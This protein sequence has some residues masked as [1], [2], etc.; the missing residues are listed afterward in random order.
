MRGIEKGRKLGMV[1]KM[2]FERN[3]RF[4]MDFNVRP[5]TN[6]LLGSKTY[7][8]RTQG[9]YKLAKYLQLLQDT[10]H[11]KSW[12]YETTKFIFP[13]DSY[14]VDFDVRNND[15]TFEYYELKGYITAKTRRNVKLLAKYRPEVRL[16]MVFLNAKDMRKMRTWAKYV[17]RVCLLS[18]L[19][20][21]IV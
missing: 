11:I 5:A 19:T 20:R 2:G 10:G 3:R 8:F 13:D 15:D 4:A 21:G 9:E 18:E 17:Y 14:L 6:V 1:E 16:T 7:S 12:S